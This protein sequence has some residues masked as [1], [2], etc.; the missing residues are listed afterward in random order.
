MKKEFKMVQRDLWIGDEL[1]S[2]KFSLWGNYPEKINPPET[3]S[4]LYLFD[5]NERFVLAGTKT[6]GKVFILFDKTDGFET[7][8]N[9][10]NNH[11]L[12]YKL[13]DDR[14]I[15]LPKFQ[16]RFFVL[17]DWDEYGNLS[18]E[19]IY[20]IIIDENNHIVDTGNLDIR[21]IIQVTHQIQI[22]EIKL[23]D[24]DTRKER[25]GLFNGRNWICELSKV[26][27]LGVG[28]YYLVYV[29]SPEKRIFEIVPSEE[30][31]D[32][33]PY[34]IVETE[35]GMSWRRFGLNYPL[36]VKRLSDGKCNIIEA[37]E[38]PKLDINK[39]LKPFILKEWVDDIRLCPRKPG[40]GLEFLVIVKDG[41]TF[42]NIPVLSQKSKKI[43]MFECDYIVKLLYISGSSI[44]ILAKGD[45]LKVFWKEKGKYIADEENIEAFEYE[46]IKATGYLVLYTE[47]EKI[48]L[49]TENT[50]NWIEN[51]EFDK[52]NDNVKIAYPD[53]K[54]TEI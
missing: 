20:K 42:F 34:H 2:K 16:S 15:E 48:G 30:K 40:I 39:D 10:L 54:I 24:P 6:N 22:P 23:M 1:V 14:K 44:G 41:K 33:G 4:D 17:Y 29:D 46:V 47:S 53:G 7:K 38:Y 21:D 43:E 51:I 25:F 26:P 11:R 32:G 52:M 18:K 28:Y 9:R 19:D 8:Y 31:I 49:F 36:Y 3:V 50:F 35:K 37:E 45:Y 5:E 12:M 27:I 13:Y